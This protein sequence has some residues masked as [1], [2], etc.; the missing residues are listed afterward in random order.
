MPTLIRK[1]FYDSIEKFNRP[2]RFGFLTI[3]ILR[4]F[5]AFLLMMHMNG[6]DVPSV[7][8]HIGKVFLAVYDYI[9]VNGHFKHMQMPLFNADEASKES[10]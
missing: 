5:G 2:C 10:D 3:A 6:N 8:I 4:N 9:L 1:A 7:G